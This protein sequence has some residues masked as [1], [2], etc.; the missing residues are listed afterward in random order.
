MKWFVVIIF[1]TTPGDVYIFHEP[2]FK[3]REECLVTLWE[4]KEAV[5]QKL[6]QE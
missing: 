1:N 2:V 3:S 5:K 4:S 6:L